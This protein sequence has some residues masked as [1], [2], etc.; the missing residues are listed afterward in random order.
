MLLLLLLCL[1]FFCHE[2]VFKMYSTLLIFSSLHLDFES[3]W[4]KFSWYPIT[5][6]FVQLLSF[7]LTNRF[8]NNLDFIHA[9]S[10]RYGSKFIFFPIATQFLKHLLKNLFF[11]SDM[12]C[13]LF[14]IVEYHTYLGLFIIFLFYPT[15]LSLSISLPHTYR[16]FMIFLIYGR[17]HVSLPFFLKL[18]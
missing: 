10:L 12:G 18:F 16:S 2:T 17:A 11:P 8:L 4:E 14:H 7:F 15:G 3:N 9:C 5:V 1:V 6:V 13:L